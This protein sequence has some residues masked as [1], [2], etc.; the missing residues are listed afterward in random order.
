MYGYAY[1]ALARSL[2]SPPGAF[3]VLALL[4]LFL[5]V[6][7]M[8]PRRFY[9]VRH[10]E[11][12]LNAQGIRQ[13]EGGGLSE[14]GRGQ[15]DRAGAYLAHF[16]I[17]LILASPF[18]RTKET[19]ELINAHL[20]VPVRYSRLLAERRNP[21]EIIGKRGDDPQVARII[22]AIDKGYH[23]DEYRYGD[24]ENFV[25]LKKRARRCLG[26]LAREGTLETCVVTHSIFLKMLIAYLLYREE[27]HAAD[28]VKLS[29]F[30]AS[31]NAAITVCEWHPWKAWNARRG[32]EVI[33]YNEQ[34]PELP[35]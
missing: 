22:D 10:G 34:P 11:T 6:L 28:Y 8:R 18:E 16:P 25:D 32:W 21:S 24:E 33:T 1:R 15:A 26:Y 17:T 3:S 27:L 14:R 19:A 20:V 4:F 29:F 30:N 9:F 35:A 7:R 2:F 13:G 5:L 23:G 31:D 12:R